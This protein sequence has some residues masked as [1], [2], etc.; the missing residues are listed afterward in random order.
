MVRSKQLGYVSQSISGSTSI[1]IGGP[2]S[3]GV[4]IVKTMTIALLGGDVGY[5]F[6]Q[7]D[8]GLGG[9]AMLDGEYPGPTSYVAHL[10][11]MWHV[12]EHPSTLGLGVSGT[13]V[14]QVLVSGAELG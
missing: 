14:L 12:I 3:G 7:T 11:A 4:W 10:R 2:P 8:V 9:T 5:W 6:L 13:G 1:P